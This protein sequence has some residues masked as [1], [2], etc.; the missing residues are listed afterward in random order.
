MGSLVGGNMSLAACF[1]Q[2]L[3]AAKRHHDHSNFYKGKNLLGLAYNFSFSFSLVLLTTL[4]LVQHQYGRKHGGTQTDMVLEELRVLHLDPV[5]AG[6][7]RGLWVW[8]VLLKL[9][10]PPLV[11]YFL[12]QGHT[13]SNKTT[14]P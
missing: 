6:R 2:G 7:E 14:P 12:Q 8:F 9:Q 13:S 4:D 10:S 5:T 1:S 3:I 11:T